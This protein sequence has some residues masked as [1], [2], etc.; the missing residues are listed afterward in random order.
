MSSFPWLEHRTLAEV[1]ETE[2]LRALAISDWGRGLQA[3]KW[4]RLE[5][6]TGKERAHNPSTRE[7]RDRL[8]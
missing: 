7:W 6:L 4:P 1:E 2:R 3:S 8:P 5:K